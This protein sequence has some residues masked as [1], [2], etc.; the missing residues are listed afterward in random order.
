MGRKASVFLQTC[1][2]WKN[3]YQLFSREKLLRQICCADG[4]QSKGSGSWRKSAASIEENTI[5]WLVWNYIW[6]RETCYRTRNRWIYLQGW[7]KR[8]CLIDI[9]VGSLAEIETVNKRE[10]VRR[11]QR[12]TLPHSKSIARG[13]TRKQEERN[14]GRWELMKTR[15]EPCAVGIGVGLTVQSRTHLSVIVSNNPTSI[16]TVIYGLFC[17]RKSELCLRFFLLL[18]FLLKLCAPRRLKK[19]Q[20]VLCD[21]FYISVGRHVPPSVM[22]L[23]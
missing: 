10:G 20:I 1:N 4:F 11:E 6:N 7:R 23:E 9:K 12:G 22:R 17:G 19:F 18:F 2:V 13:Y 8:S 3:S 15:W 21:W 5:L 16:E 14:R